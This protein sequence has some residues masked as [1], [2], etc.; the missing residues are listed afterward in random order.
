MN[1]CIYLYRNLVNGKCY[2]GQTICP[3]KKRHYDHL[4]QDSY[5]DRALKKYGEENFELTILES[6]I[7][8]QELLDKKEIYYIEKYGSYVNGYNQTRGGQG[9]AR[10]SV[11]P[12][13]ATEIAELILGTNLTF[14]EIGEMCG[15]SVYQVSEANLGN[16]GYHLDGFRYP[17]RPE[18]ITA[19]HTDAQADL[20]KEYLLNTDYSF[21]KIADLAGVDYYAVCDINNGKRRRDSKREYPLRSPSVQ[22]TVLDEEVV[23]I[24]VD[25]LK[26]SNK[27]ADQI[28]AEL[29]IPGYTVGQI[30]RGKSSWCKML[31]ESYPIR[32]KAH[33]SSES[34]RELCRKLSDRD[35]LSIADMLKNTNLNVEEIAKRFAVSRATIDRINQGK[36]WSFVTNEVFPIR[37][38]NKQNL[39][40]NE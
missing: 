20:V 25:M 38:N 27:S 24:I 35:V 21:S 14:K 11:D 1:G 5:F 39:I 29:G 6:D 13:L 23:K 2:V 22:K 3:I 33:R 36:Q 4:H 9:A 32:K 30:N 7:Q 10:R 28:G 17:L 26:H 8:T 15:V 34:P 37:R 19:K 16:G 12:K 18:R 31:D 40:L